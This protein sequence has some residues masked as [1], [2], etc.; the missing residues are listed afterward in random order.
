MAFGGLKQHVPIIQR[1]GLKFENLPE[2]KNIYI[3]NNKWL[4]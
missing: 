2:I 1:N 4:F 3:H